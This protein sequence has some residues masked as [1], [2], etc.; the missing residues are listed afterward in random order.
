MN[1]ISILRILIGIGIFGINAKIIWDWM[2]KDRVS[3]SC[4]DVIN[5]ELTTI[6]ENTNELTEKLNKLH[7]VI[8]GNG[9]PEESIVFR[10]AQ[11]EEAIKDY[12]K[13]KESKGL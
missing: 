10:V 7:E 4:I 5:V 1:E 2:T 9:K 11:I 13:L 8:I 12:K 6:S 3:K